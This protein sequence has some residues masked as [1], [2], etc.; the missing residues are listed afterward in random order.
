[1]ARTEKELKQY[2]KDN[3][4]SLDVFKINQELKNDHPDNRESIIQSCKK[5]LE[6]IKSKADRKILEFNSVDI[7]D[8][9]WNE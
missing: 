5:Y 8:S 6:D 2:I 4:L 3:I 1:M 9:F 7:E